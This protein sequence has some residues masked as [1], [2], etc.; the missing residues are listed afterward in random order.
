MNDIYNFFFRFMVWLFQGFTLGH[1]ICSYV[2]LLKKGWYPI[3]NVFFYHW[4]S[5]GSEILVDNKYLKKNY[6]E[7]VC[8]AS[9]LFSCHFEMSIIPCFVIVSFFKMNL[10]AWLFIL[11]L[12]VIFLPITLIASCYSI[13]PLNINF[14]GSWLIS[15]SSICDTILHDFRSTMLHVSE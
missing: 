10:L 3:L 6:A 9:F 15:M 5:D 11:D 1:F 13:T 4:R 8:K 12:Q 14:F 2:F 7:L